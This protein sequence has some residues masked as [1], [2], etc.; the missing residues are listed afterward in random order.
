[1]SWCRRLVPP[2]ELENGKAVIQSGGLAWLSEEYFLV[3]L[4]TP[5]IVLYHGY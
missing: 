5:T 3:V 4:L 2:K 1:M